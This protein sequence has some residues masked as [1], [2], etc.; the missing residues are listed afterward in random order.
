MDDEL[1]INGVTYR[2]VEAEPAF[3]VGDRVE[4]VA[5]CSPFYHPGDT[6]IIQGEFGN[7]AI[8]KFDTPRMTSTDSVW[9]VSY[10]N[11][12]HIDTP[13]PAPVFKVG[14]RVEYIKEGNN[15]VDLAIG[16]VG[17]VVKQ[18]GE[19]CYVEFSDVSWWCLLDQIR[20]TTPRVIEVIQEAE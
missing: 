19:Y 10:A 9:V 11:L 17:T 8:V 1:V 15:I 3:K 7:K 5:N 2:K 18:E 4:T 14:D 13:A 20:T 12:R 6:G 16:S